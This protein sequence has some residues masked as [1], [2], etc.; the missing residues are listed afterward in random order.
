MTKT[1]KNNT[2]FLIHQPCILFYPI[3]Y[4]LFITLKFLMLLKPIYRFNFLK[5]PQ[6][7]MFM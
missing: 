1:V 7:E 4:Y 2:I 3:I 5:H 6:I